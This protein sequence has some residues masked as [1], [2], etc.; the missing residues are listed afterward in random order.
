MALSPI[1]A[2][3]LQVM[4]TRAVFLDRDGVINRPLVRNGTPYPPQNSSEFE[5]MDGIH[6]TLRTLR[7][8]GFT[9]LIFTNQ[10]DVARGTQTEAQ[11]DE[12]HQ[13]ILAELPIQHIYSCLHDDVA[14]CDCRKPKAGM[15]FAGRDDFGVDLSRSWVVGDRWRDIEAGRAAGCRTVLVQHGYNERQATADYE[16]R[17][18]PELLEIIKQDE[19]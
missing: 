8:R 11:L 6:Q 10:P 19:P 15:L 2:G 1:S 17:S 5:W 13:R 16:V 12:F 3:S 7:E 9:L 4:T 18:I 14:Q